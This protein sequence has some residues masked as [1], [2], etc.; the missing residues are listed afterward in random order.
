MKIKSAVALVFVLVCALGAIKNSSADEYWYAGISQGIKI[1][2]APWGNSNWQG[3]YPTSFDVG[4]RWNFYHDSWSIEAE[5]ISN[6]ADGPPFND[7]KETWLDVLWV[8][9]EVKFR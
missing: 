3:D 4:Y 6:I 7:R 5:H 2:N 1:S 8:K 9:Y